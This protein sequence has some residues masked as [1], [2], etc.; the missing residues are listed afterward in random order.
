MADIKKILIGE[1][2][3]LVDANLSSNAT[4]GLDAVNDWAK[5]Y[6]LAYAL[7]AAFHRN[8]TSIFLGFGSHMGTRRHHGEYFL[9]K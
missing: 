9:F 3:L 8:G 2:S 6:E 4:D 1:H 5:L 7:V